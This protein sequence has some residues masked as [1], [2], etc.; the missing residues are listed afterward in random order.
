M[1]SSV[2]TVGIMSELS[3]DGLTWDECAARWK[4]SVNAVRGRAK[5]LGIPIAYIDRIAHWPGNSSSLETPSRLEVGDP[6]ERLRCSWRVSA[7]QE[8]E[9]KG[10]SLAE[11]GTLSGQ[12]R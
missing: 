6:H 1:P 5:Q 2:S 9:R 4:L 7:P 12:L 3:K 10:R 11:R 8:P